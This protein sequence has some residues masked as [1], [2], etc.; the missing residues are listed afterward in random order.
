MK[1]LS[2][3]KC[4]KT[5]RDGDAYILIENNKNVCVCNKCFKKEDIKTISFEKYLDYQVI[6]AAHTSP[7]SAKNNIDILLELNNV[8]VG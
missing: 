8:R 3:E 2:C 1:P 5:L 4:N 6:L 7:L